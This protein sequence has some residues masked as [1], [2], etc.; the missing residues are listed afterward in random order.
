MSSQ[1]C[2]ST[3][4][5]DRGQLCS[6]VCNPRV[7]TVVKGMRSLLRAAF[8]FHLAENA[9]KVRLALAVAG[10]PLLDRLSCLLGSGGSSRVVNCL[11][12]QAYSGSH[13][14]AIA[15]AVRLTSG[16]GAVVQ[17]ELCSRLVAI[18][19]A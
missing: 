10:R 11:A 14:A 1:I 16:P 8:C 4:Y 2:Q 6:I 18:V 3:L 9:T 17:A 7:L 19:S 13:P 15:T 5:M 12:L